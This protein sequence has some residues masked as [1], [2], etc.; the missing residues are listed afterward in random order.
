MIS[1]FIN[2][3]FTICNTN[4]ELHNLS[5]KWNI[6]GTY[7]TIS[8][9]NNLQDNILPKYFKHN[10]YSSFQ[11]QLYLYNFLKEENNNDEF[12]E[13]YFN[14]NFLKNNKELLKNIN[15]KHEK[16]KNIEE[17]NDEN[18][19]FC[20]EEEMKEIKK[21]NVKL[22]NDLNN[23]V[24]YIEKLVLYIKQ[25]NK[26]MLV[27]F[28]NLANKNIENEENILKLNS[29]LKSMEEKNNTISI[30]ME[31]ITSQEN[32]LSLFQENMKYNYNSFFNINES[33]FS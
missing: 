12:G 5:I 1:T 18:K 23:L 27:I 25:A 28:V 24:K 2:K 8:N 30:L 22:T 29:K 11:K 21:T 32:K 20:Y 17:D 26:E 19:R 15:R 16:R 6:N 14:P 13:T 33:L 4:D 7:I 10:K 9:L 3:L 31:K